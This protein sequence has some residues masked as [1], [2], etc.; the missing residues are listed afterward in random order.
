MPDDPAQ[1]ISPDEHP[2]LKERTGEDIITA[3]G[4]TLLRGADDKAGVAIIMDMAHFLVSHPDCT[5]GKIRILFTPDE[6][7]GRGVDKLDMD[8]LGANFGY[9]LDAGERGAFEDETFSA[10][11]VQ[12][13][14]HGVSAHPGYA[15]DKLVNAIK[16]A[17]AF[18]DALPKGE[19]S[20]EATEGRYGFVH[21]VRSSGNAEKMTVDLIIR[22]FVTS[23]LAAYEAHLK[24]IV[25]RRHWPVFPA[26]RRISRSRNNIAI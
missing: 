9:T 1:V 19:W 20:P 5:H 11:G 26:P 16:V 13:V 2:Y 8:R 15:K 22:D 3:S 23:R 10:D 12:V 14:F 18:V 17:A 7:I 24:G 4:T 6:E 21:P 25:R